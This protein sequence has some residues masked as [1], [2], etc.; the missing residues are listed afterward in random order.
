MQK[1]SLFSVVTI[2]VAVVASSIAVGY[3]Y[4]KYGM[5][6]ASAGLALLSIVS[7]SALSPLIFRKDKGSVAFDE[8]D[9]IIS[10]RSA[11]AGFMAAYL[12]VGLACMVP[13]SVMGP[14]AT[15]EVH[16]LPMIFMGAGLSHFFVYSLAILIQY[17]CA[18]KGEMP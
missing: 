5:P 15:L 16:W 11:L 10:R 14:R 18:G 2:S 4:G 6:K 8:R 7:I 12:F 1:I 3:L 13:F 17:G 9:R